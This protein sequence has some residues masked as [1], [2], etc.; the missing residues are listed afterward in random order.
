MSEI[1]D[2]YKNPCEKFDAGLVN[3]YI[4]LDY[5]LSNP[6]GIV[7]DHSWGTDYLDLKPL[8]KAGETITSLELTP[9]NNPEYLQFNRED[10]GRDCIHGDYLSRIISLKYLKDVDQE[11]RPTTGDVYMYNEES[12]TFYTFNL[13]DFV[14]TT[15]ANITKL[16][17]HIANLQQQINNLDARVT[18]LE[19]TVANHETRLQ[20]I[21]EILTPP[22]NMQSNARVAWGNINLYSDYTN[23]SLKTSG[24]YT[25]DLN[26]NVTND[27]YFS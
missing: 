6:T 4:D 7:L 11:T 16:F 22:A 9:T 14:D 21:D 19:T 10:G 20:T 24:L 27:E 2:F 15:N 17:A 8:I 5:D 25:H 12:D 1:S 18:A 13:Q 23:N 3:A 26:S